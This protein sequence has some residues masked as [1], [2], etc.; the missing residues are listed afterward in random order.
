MKKIIKVA[1]MT[2][3]ICDLQPI[4][5]STDTDPLLPM[6]AHIECHNHVYWTDVLGEDEAEVRKA[7]SDIDGKISNTVKKLE[8]NPGLDTDY[9][10]IFYNRKITDQAVG[11]LSAALPDYD[12]VAAEDEYDIKVLTRPNIK[13]H[14]NARLERHT[15]S[16]FATAPADIFV[17]PYSYVEDGYLLEKAVTMNKL[18]EKRYYN[19]IAGVLHRLDVRKY[20]RIYSPDDISTADIGMDTVEKLARALTEECDDVAFI[21]SFPQRYEISLRMVVPFYKRIFGCTKRVP[22][23]KVRDC[24][25]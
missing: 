21:A 6:Y 20:E 18:P 9:K 5:F 22:R 19:R 7:L 8:D 10:K 25:Q 14:V 11:L 3:R 15:L 23:L 2:T 4:S 16:D 1:V 24:T 13:I 17:E 12:F